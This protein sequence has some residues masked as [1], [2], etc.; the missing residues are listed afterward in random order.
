MGSVGKWVGTSWRKL[1]RYMGRRGLTIF[2]VKDG[3]HAD[4]L[5]RCGFDHLR[6]AETLFG[7]SPSYFDSA[8]YLSH[9]G[10]ESLLK[11]WLLHITGEFE[12]T[13]SCKKLYKALVRKCDA[14]AL[15]ED[16]KEVLRIL[17]R[18]EALRYP[19]RN[20]PTSVG[21]EDWGKIQNLIEEI[22]QMLPK[23]LT[24][25]LDEMEPTKKAGRVLMKKRI[26]NSES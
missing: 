1:L 21:T 4:D 7:G 14:P 13:H 26:P 24:A 2:S 18:Y 12:A 25:K 22:N 11:A 23:D 16:Q 19:N 9:L 17:D 6:A 20:A 15:I 8:G 10:V 5:L 3:V